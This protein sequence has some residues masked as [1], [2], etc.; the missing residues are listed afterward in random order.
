MR[1]PGDASDWIAGF[2]ILHDRKMSTFRTSEA[3]AGGTSITIVRGA[4]GVGTLVVRTVKSAI[5]FAAMALLRALTLLSSRN[6]QR[7]F[8]AVI[9]LDIPL[10]LDTHFL[11][12][13]DLADLGSLGGL[14][15][16]VTTLALAALYAGWIIEIAVIRHGPRPGLRINSP[17]A[18]YVLISALSMFAAKDMLLASFEVW[19]LFQTLLVFVY[20][21]SRVRSRD[22]TIFIIRV[23]LIGLALESSIILSQHAGMRIDVPGHPLSIEESTIG[24]GDYERF[25][26]T[27]GHPNAAGWYISLLLAPALSVI[28]VPLGRWDKRLAGLA[29]GLGI[30]ALVF[31]FSR[32][33]WT[34]FAISLAVMGVAMW[35][36]GK[37]RVKNLVVLTLVMLAVALVY[38]GEIETRLL[39]DDGGSAISRLYLMQIAF[40]M[41]SDHPV[42]GV[43]ANNF[44]SVMTQYFKAGDY[45]Y[46]VHNQY[47]LIW[48]EVGIGGLVAFLAF[49]ISAIRRGWRVWRSDDPL[50]SPL[51]LG[52]TAGII[53]HMS[54][55]FVDLFRGRSEIQLLWLMASLITTLSWMNCRGRL[56]R[57][58]PVA[59]TELAMHV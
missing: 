42:L 23:L 20:F 35:N 12:R 40:K 11:Y 54:H 51:A 43:G 37:L 31:T 56:R 3:D 6:V 49:L 38:R 30:V 59:G 50:L 18:A 21:A 32:G 16:S 52:L 27:L 36:R 41:I 19:V 39:A 14:G 34:A 33:G 26:G 46:A 4:V 53:G 2:L 45:L 1:V 55:M 44:P 29:F 48:A 7:F 22:D 5:F 24:L 28:A 9:L 25:G 13:R 57:A 15:V 10:L 58:S 17:L 47:L 8:I